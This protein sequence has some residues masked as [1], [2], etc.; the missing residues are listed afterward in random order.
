LQDLQKHEGKG[1]MCPTSILQLETIEMFIKMPGF[2]YSIKA[3][4]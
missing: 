1:I 4:W 2:K 3:K